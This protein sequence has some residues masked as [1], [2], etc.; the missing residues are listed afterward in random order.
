MCIRDRHTAEYERDHDV[1]TSLLNRRA[2]T[3]KMNKLFK[4][5]DQLK[6]AALVMSDLDNLKYINDT[7]GHDCG[8]DY[9]RLMANVLKSSYPPQHSIISRI[10]GEMCIRDRVMNLQTIV[11]RNVNPLD[12]AVITVGKLNAG[13]VRNVIADKAEIIG[14]MRSFSDANYEMMKQ[15]MHAVAEAI[16]QMFN[17]EVEL[18]IDDFHAVVNNDE[19]LTAML[20]EVVGEAYA[21]IAPRMIAEDFSFYQ[22]IVPC[23]LYTSRCV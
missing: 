17:V 19:K 9:I 14:T 16:A 3:E 22:Q 13:E 8:D 15:R 10:S 20:A 2:Y 23:L 4:Q 6:V 21:E 18:V 5:H 7:F 1:L 12:S 11:S